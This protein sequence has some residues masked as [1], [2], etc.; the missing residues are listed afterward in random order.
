MTK[1]CRS[2]KRDMRKNFVPRSRSYLSGVAGMGVALLR[3]INLS[4]GGPMGFEDATN[5]E[6]RNGE[7]FETPRSQGDPVGGMRRIREKVK[8]F[9]EGVKDK[10]PREALHNIGEAAGQAKEYVNEAA[11]QA[12]EYVEHTTMQ[13][14][15]GDAA[16][17]IK[18]Y[19]FSAMALGMTLG[20]FLSRR[21]D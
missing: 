12:R 8:D 4:I 13:S 9:V 6:R 16:G 21:R 15:L 10:S 5:E 18:R 20:F 17:L 19:P 1:V 11:G 14:M 3:D 7:G 2:Q